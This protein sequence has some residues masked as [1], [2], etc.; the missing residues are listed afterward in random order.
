[1]PETSKIPVKKRTIKNRSRLL[2]AEPMKEGE[3]TPEQAMRLL[4]SMKDE[5]QRVQLDERRAVR[6]VYNDW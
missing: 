2:E 3:M 1:M 4:Q 6:P 5:E